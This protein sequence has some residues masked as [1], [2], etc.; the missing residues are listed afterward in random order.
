MDARTTNRLTD[1]VFGWYQYV[2]DFTGQFALD[3]LHRLAREGAVIWEPFSGSGTTLVA[4]K[5]LGLKSYGYD[6]SPFMVDVAKTKVDWA[7]RTSK[8]G[9]ST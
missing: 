3:W 7:D 6:I 2:Q 1:G 9:G 8:T 5:L 4:S